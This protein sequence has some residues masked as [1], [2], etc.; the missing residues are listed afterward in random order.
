MQVA[1]N[2]REGLAM[3][4]LGVDRGFENREVLE[5]IEDVPGIESARVAR[6]P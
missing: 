1:R 2:A 6:V 4:V 5:A 3:M